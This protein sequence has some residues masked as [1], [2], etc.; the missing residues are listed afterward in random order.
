MLIVLFFLSSSQRIR[1][2]DEDVL[3]DEDDEEEDI[4]LDDNCKC[5]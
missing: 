4:D 2:N 5:L 3:S 1:L